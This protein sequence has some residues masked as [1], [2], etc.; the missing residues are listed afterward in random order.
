[1]QP[2]E[3]NRLNLP[4]GSLETTILK[5]YK[6]AYTHLFISF[7]LDLF[8]KVYVQESVGDVYKDLCGKT[9]AM[10]YF[11]MRGLLNILGL[12]VDCGGRRA[13]L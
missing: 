5:N 8:L 9:E 6:I 7:D 2:V 4:E 12:W 13:A 1:M 3:L 11:I 10:G